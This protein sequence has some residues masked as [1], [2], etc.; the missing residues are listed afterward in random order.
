[1]RKAT[2]VIALLVAM[3]LLIPAGAALA[4][5]GKQGSSNASCIGL[6]ASGISPKGSSDEFA[7]GVPEVHAF[8]RGLLG[9]RGV[10]AIIS[11]V[12]KVHAGS[13]EACDAE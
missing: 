11:Q 4:D 10:G 7:G 5:P 1:M 9:T 3:L 12:A 13:H 6:E 8:L 2:I